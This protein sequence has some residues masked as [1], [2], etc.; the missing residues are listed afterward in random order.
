MDNALNKVPTQ[1]GKRMPDM[2]IAWESLPSLSHLLERREAAAHDAPVWAE[3]MPLSFD[4]MQLS[5]PFHEPLEGL[6]IRE[7]NEPD[8]FKVFFG[9]A[10]RPAA[11]A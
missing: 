3:T 4:A 6:S 5:S 9:D 7:V 11:R 2:S 10:Q 1:L 8:I